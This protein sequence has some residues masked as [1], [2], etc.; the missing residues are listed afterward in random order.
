MYTIVLQRL[1]QVKSVEKPGITRREPATFGL[2]TILA[3]DLNVWDPIFSCVTIEN[4]G[5]SSTIA[6]KDYRIMPGEYNLY[7]DTTAVP[8]PIPYRDMKQGVLLGS[9]YDPAFKNRR[10]FI[11]AGNYPQDTEGCILLQSTY[12]FQK[13]QG[14]GAGSMRACQSFYEFIY[15][16]PLIDKQVKDVVLIIKEEH[17]FTKPF[18]LT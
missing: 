9:K 18:S 17:E 10:I 14:F 7:L 8:L 13:N 4:G 16:Q 2:L 15:K 12:D 5:R 1:G 3:K 6:N 11:H